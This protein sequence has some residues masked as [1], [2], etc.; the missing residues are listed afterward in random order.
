MCVLDWDRGC[1]RDGRERACDSIDSHL[2]VGAVLND[3]LLNTNDRK[4]RERD[5]DVVTGTRY[6]LG[7]GV[8]SE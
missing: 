7:G 5:Y 8:S 1:G 2:L 4:Q 6:A 3:W